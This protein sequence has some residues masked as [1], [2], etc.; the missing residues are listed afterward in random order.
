MYLCLALATLPP[1]TPD[2]APATG[3]DLDDALQPALER[4][5]QAVAAFRGRPVSP[6]A[7]AAFENALQQ[8][9]QELGRA[10]LQWAYNHLEPDD[11]PALPRH[12]PFQGS[13]FGRLTCKTPQEVSTLFGKVTL[14]RL[15]YRAAPEAGE[16]VLFPLCQALGLL[17]GAT[18][19]L[20][21]RAARYQAEAGATQGRTLQRLRQ[22]QGVAWGV[23]KLRQ[24]T[25]A[26]AAALEEH[27]PQ[28]QAEQ[29]VRWLAQAF[30]APGRHRPV[31]A[32][33]RDG[34]TLGVRLRGCTLYEVASTGT[35]TVY[36]R[37]GR[38]LGTVYLAQTPEPGQAAL[39]AQLTGL[40]TE[41]LGRWQG[42]LPRLCYVTDAGDNEIAYY[43]RVL[44]RL[45]HPR[46]GQRLE[47]FWVLDYYHAAERLSAM[48]EALFGVGGRAW[49]WVRKMQKL[50]LK[51]GGVSR[52]LHSAA[53]LREQYGLRGQRRAEFQ[54]GYAYLRD[55]MAHLRYAD[56]RRWGVPLGSGV[57]EA[58]CKTVYAQRLKLSGMSWG[59][60]GAQ[61]ILDL[62]VVLLSGVWDEAYARVLAGFEQAQVRGQQAAHRKRA[63]IAA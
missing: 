18:P 36:D 19:A 30:A 42:P 24:V 57:T 39:G 54:R 8:Q 33:G 55:R 9:A 34:I 61:T 63:E 10:V 48:A 44:R 11:M 5:R 52:V 13:R 46:T 49:A 7:T 16:P 14:R 31:L 12:L 43:R 27:R 41:V 37:R 3:P 62:R 51:P 4:I 15:G 2:E 56:Y 47:W 26:V 53:A 29:V 28:A 59:R 17:H 38:R 1:G 23:K 6:A 60:Q 25:A 22:E 35:L 21:E 58:G 32:I 20:A 45:R 50:L 40:L